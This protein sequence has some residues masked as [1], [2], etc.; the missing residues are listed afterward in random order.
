MHQLNILASGLKKRINHRVK[1][2]SKTSIKTSYSLLMVGLLF[3][4][5]IEAQIHSF[6]VYEEVLFASPK[7]FDLT[8]DIYVP[9]TGKE[10]YP[11]LVIW[12]GGGWL[13]NTNQIMDEMSGYVASNAEYIVCNVNYRLLGDLNNTTT[14]NEIVEDVFGS[15]LW[16]KYNISEYGGD[17]T[18]VAITGDS[19]G[20][21]LASMV[22]TS[23]RVL[24]SDGFEGKPGF[25]PS[26]LPEGK[27]AEE[28]ARE[29]GLS[30]QAAIISYGVL[31]V[32]DRSRNGY[33]TDKNG[34][35]EWGGVTARGFFGNEFNYRDHPEL[36]KALSPIYNIPENEEYLLPPQ[37]HHVGSMDEVTTPELIGEYVEALKE[38][39]HPVEFEIY[40]GKNHAYL[41]NGCNEFLGNCFDEDAVP[42][43]QKIISFLDEHLA[44]D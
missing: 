38:K 40:D 25:T 8:M 21:H 28:I 23:G 35:W 43:L 34:F 13:I 17:S 9:D 16:I 2:M 20:G 42:V 11:V 5:L 18:R 10:E 27:T 7:G 1:L 33:E 30:V 37:F 41:D 32:L 22:L 19:A 15:L 14:L 3:A 26:W 36:Y 44:D 4:G 29:D 31:D 6:S 12:H 39:G 24:D